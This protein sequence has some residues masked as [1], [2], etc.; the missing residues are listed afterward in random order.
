MGRLQRKPL[1]QKAKGGVIMEF[2]VTKTSLYGRCEK[3]CNC[4]G[5]KKESFDYIEV[6]SLTEE[7]FNE[8][9]SHLEGLWRSKGINHKSGD[10]MIERTF[11]NKKVGWFLEIDTLQELIGFM[12]KVDEDI[13]IHKNDWNHDILE[14]EIYDTWR[15]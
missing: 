1:L 12:K 5:L 11:P 15:E 8:K 14:L 3:P 4:S 7:E 10:G 6:R 9:F 13:V 2:L